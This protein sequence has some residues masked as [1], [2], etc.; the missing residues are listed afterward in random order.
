MYASENKEFV[1]K[2]VEMTLSNIN[3][4]ILTVE[5]NNDDGINDNLEQ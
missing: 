4:T 2:S 5:Q 1:E 3:D